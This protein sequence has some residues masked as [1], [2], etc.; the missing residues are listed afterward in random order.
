MSQAPPNQEFYNPPPPSKG[1]GMSTGAVIAIVLGILL[2]LALLIGGLLFAMLLPAVHQVRSAARRTQSMNNVRQI[3]LSMH[4]HEAAFGKLP[5]DLNDDDGVAL[6]SWR[7]AILPQL[8]QGNLYDSIDKST[9]WHQASNGDMTEI[10]VPVYES[11]RGL[12][13]PGVTHY[14]RVVGEG[15]VMSDSL[16]LQDIEESDGTAHTA[17]LLE[18]PESLIPWGEPRDITLDDAVQIIQ[19]S[20]EPSGTIV[21]MADGSVTMVPSSTSGGDIIKLFKYNDGPSSITQ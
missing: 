7:T 21:G 11:P 14:L 18:Y 20:A 9:P 4:N 1:G 3:V 16:S 15:T 17:L 5:N 13:T 8:E 10:S 6:H 12:P 2:L 19:G